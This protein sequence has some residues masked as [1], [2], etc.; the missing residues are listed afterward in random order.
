M[1]DKNDLNQPSW[2]YF[3]VT[4]KER[5]YSKYCTTEYECYFFGNFLAKTQNLQHTVVVH[6]IVHKLAYVF[7]KLRYASNYKK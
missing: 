7:A 5:C 3:H 4:E 6:K 2:S 1:F